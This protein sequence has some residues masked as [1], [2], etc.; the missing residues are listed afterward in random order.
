MMSQNF[1][2]QAVMTGLT[3]REMGDGEGY[4]ALCA[5]LVPSGEELGQQ[6]TIA[7]VL[8][9]Q[10]PLLAG[11]S[12]EGVSDWRGFVAEQEERFGRTLTVARKPGG[13]SP[14]EVFGV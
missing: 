13:W 14:S 12:V 4:R 3:G 7:S 5:F 11:V 8:A 10:H 9:A 1:S 2:L 6:K